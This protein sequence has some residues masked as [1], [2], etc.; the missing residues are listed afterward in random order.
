MI[1]RQPSYVGEK[2]QSGKVHQGERKHN[3]YIIRQE[4]G[5]VVTGMTLDKQLTAFCLSVWSAYY[6]QQLTAVC[7]LL[8]LHTGKT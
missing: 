8:R 6:D 1:K 5:I 2:N 3:L 4:Y 7:L